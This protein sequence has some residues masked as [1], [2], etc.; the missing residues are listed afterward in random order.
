MVVL[1]APRTVA[2]TVTGDFLSRKR[3]LN[4]P[5][6]NPRDSQGRIA[7]CFRRHG[8]DPQDLRRAITRRAPDRA[9]GSVRYEFEC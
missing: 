6:N 8:N 4:P 9:A 2:P 7:G 3:V 5:K 1:N